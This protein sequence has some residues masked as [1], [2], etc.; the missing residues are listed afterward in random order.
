[1]RDAGENHKEARMW[2]RASTH[3][4][5]SV[6]VGCWNVCTI[7]STGK[8]AQVCREMTRYKV[9]ILGISEYRWTGWAGYDIGRGKHSILRQ[10]SSKRSGNNYVRVNLPVGDRLD[11]A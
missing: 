9:E 8:S 5:K 7:Y 1:M 11:Y 2:I 10:L 6:C 3:P 4:K